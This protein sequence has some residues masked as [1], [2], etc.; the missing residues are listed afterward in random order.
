MKQGWAIVCA[1]ALA[2]CGE[3]DSGGISQADAGMADRSAPVVDSGS[4]S[5]IDANVAPVDPTCTSNDTCSDGKLCCGVGLVSH[6]LDPIDGACPEPDVTID[7]ARTS[8]SLSFEWKYFDE[9]NCAVIEQCVSGTGWR[10][11]MRFDTLTPNV[12]NG[13]LHVGSPSPT[14]EHFEYSECHEHFHFKNYADY[15]VK[16]A[17][18]TEV[19]LGHKQAFCLLD[20]VRVSDDP[21]VLPR[22]E[23]DCLNQ[24]INPGWG[25]LYFGT[26]DCQWVDI[27][28]VASGDYSLEI[29]I[30]KDHVLFE[31]NYDN[32]IVAVPIS[33]PADDG[34]DPTAV[35][36]S[37]NSQGLGPARECGWSVQTSGAACK[38]GA[39]I[40]IGCGGAAC[41]LSEASTC[42]GD[43]VIRI[44]EGAGACSA[45]HSIMQADDG[46]GAT[47]CSYGTFTC[48]DTGLFSVLVTSY[49]F[50]TPAV[51]VTEA[52]ANLP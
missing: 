3:K 46:C 5:G 16:N 41:G 12:G 21:S 23:H 37:H 20:T 24:G 28:D 33:I 26:I 40:P 9:T 25:D 1:A 38:P 29:S 34:P 18:G 44:C 19:A 30:N 32:N 14:D 2:A 35:C 36:D 6:C 27:T 45:Q 31:S 49:E 51:C 13:P 7:P 50:Q 52:G 39:S 10:R 42:E 48:P 11:V 22:P 15:R 43:P 8:K 4:D 47:E 17:E